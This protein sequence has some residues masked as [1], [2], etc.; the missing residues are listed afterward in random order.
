MQYTR[1]TFNPQQMGGVPCIRRLHI[2]V[3]TVVGMLV[4][5]TTEEK[6]LQAFADLEQADADI[7]ALQY[8]TETHI[9]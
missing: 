5:G 2:P 4:E 9:P 3:A 6:I 1:I 8:G 7:E